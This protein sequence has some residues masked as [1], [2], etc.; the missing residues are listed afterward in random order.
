MSVKGN[1]LGKINHD[2]SATPYVIAPKTS[3]KSPVMTLA[4][5]MRFP[6]IKTAIHTMIGATVMID[7]IA[8]M[9]VKIGDFPTSLHYEQFEVPCKMEKL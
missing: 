6:A 5:N 2:L 1:E 7:I 9:V 3:A 4:M 8:E